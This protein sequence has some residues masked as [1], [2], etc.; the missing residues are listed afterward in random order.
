MGFLGAAIGLACG[1]AKNECLWKARSLPITS[2]REALGMNSSTKYRRFLVALGALTSTAF[3]STQSHAACSDAG[4]TSFDA[5][6][7]TVVLCVADNCNTA[8]LSRTCGNIHYSSQDYE[9]PSDQW[10][11]R[12]RYHEDG[13]EDDEFFVIRNG[14]ELSTNQSQQMTCLGSTREGSCDFINDVLSKGL[15]E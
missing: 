15:S 4:V 13:V 8:L 14:L 1:C 6:P 5:S 7:H 9:S 3:M 11:F 10:L 2:I 12:V